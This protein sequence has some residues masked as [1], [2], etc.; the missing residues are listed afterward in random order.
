M[1]LLDAPTDFQSAVS[2]AYLNRRDPRLGGI[3]ALDFNS[4]GDQRIEADACTARRNHD[5]RQRDARE[6]G[7]F[8]SWLKSTPMEG[9]SLDVH[10]F[11][12]GAVG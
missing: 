9:L 4:V 10:R 7:N 5:E 3:H 11:I 2:I 8:S 1:P 12:H 6:P